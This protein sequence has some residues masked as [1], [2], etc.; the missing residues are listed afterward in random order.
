MISTTLSHMSLVPRPF[1][2]T[3]E[4]SSGDL[5]PE[6]LVDM[7]IKWSID[8]AHLLTASDDNDTCTPH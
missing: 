7:T 1:V 4:G 3:D 2:V 6:L 5:V 8:Y